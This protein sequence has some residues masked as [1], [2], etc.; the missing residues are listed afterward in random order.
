MGDK[1]TDSQHLDPRN[2][3][4]RHTIAYTLGIFAGGKEA[5]APT[6][7][8]NLQRGAVLYARRLITASRKVTRD[9]P[10][11]AAIVLNGMR[12]YAYHSSAM[13]ICSWLSAAGLAI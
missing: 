1:I 7:E 13:R 3:A 11:F 12:L 9:T 2:L 8:F 4:L 5:L 6:V 10:N